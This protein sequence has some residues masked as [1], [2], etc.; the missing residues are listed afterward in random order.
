MS[1]LSLLLPIF[2]LPT[3]FPPIPIFLPPH[4]HKHTPLYPCK[5]T[6]RSLTLTH[7]SN[8][9][10]PVLYKPPPPRISTPVHRNTL[11]FTSTSVYTFT[12]T[13]PTRFFRHPYTSSPAVHLCTDS[14]THL[15]PITPT[16]RQPNN[17]YSL[18][19]LHASAPTA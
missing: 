9:L 12:Y 5:L 8:S 6:L 7:P 1:L 13:P 2:L 19:G 18:T 10:L 11:P 4:I 14:S 3:F 16:A 17:L 15:P